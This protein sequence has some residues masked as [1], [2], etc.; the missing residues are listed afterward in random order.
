MQL[1]GVPRCG[2]QDHHWRGCTSED[3]SLLQ[4]VS[5]LSFPIFILDE[6]NETTLNLACLGTVKDLRKASVLKEGTAASVDPVAPAILANAD[7][8]T[9]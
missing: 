2:D 6:V 1:W 5:N 7:E 9:A 8:T 3:V 4:S